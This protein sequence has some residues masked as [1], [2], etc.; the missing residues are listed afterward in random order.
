MLKDM[1]QSNYLDFWVGQWDFAWKASDGTTDHGTNTTERILNG[2]VIKDNF[3]VTSGQMT[4]YIDKSY[5]VN[6]PKT[7]SGN[8]F[9]FII[10]VLIWILQKL[11]KQRS[12]C[13][14]G[15]E[16]IP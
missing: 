2:K 13:L 8:K 11:L 3:E 15:R 4:E 7:K 6:K 9:G 14:F 16:K 12:A 5:S 1:S 10:K